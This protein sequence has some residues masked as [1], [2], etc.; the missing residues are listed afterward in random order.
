MIPFRKKYEVSAQNSIG[1]KRLFDSNT[2]NTMVVVGIFPAVKLPPWWA[3]PV[4]WRFT[5]IF[6][7]YRLPPKS[8]PPKS[9]KPPTAKT[10][11]PYCIT[12]DKIPPHFGT[13]ASAKKHCQLSIPP[14][15]YR[16]LS[17]PPKGYPTLDTAYEVPPTLLTAPKIPG[18]LFVSVLCSLLFLV[19][20]VPFG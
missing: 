20:R 9:E 4:I 11:P 5:A 3:V 10:L 6:W 15:E 18:F 12:A 16:Q 8:L 19:L 7:Q 2:K 13:T 14:K 17:I 1:L